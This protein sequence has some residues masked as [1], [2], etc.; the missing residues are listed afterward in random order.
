MFLIAETSVCVDCSIEHAFSVVSNMERFG[1]WFPEVISISSM[2]DLNHGE[3]NKTYVELV[4]VPLQGKRSIEIVVKESVPCS[5]FV[6]EGR[7]FPLLPRMEIEL[8]TQAE[9][10]TNII[11]PAL[12]NLNFLES[13]I[14]SSVM[15]ATDMRSL[16]R[17]A[18][19]ARRV[20]V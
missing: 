12:I 19:H 1:E 8:V 17:P 14:I 15:N 2:N 3:V 20:Q 16:P 18:R 9:S 5:R 11:D 13:V 4:S 7:L 6:T 10:K